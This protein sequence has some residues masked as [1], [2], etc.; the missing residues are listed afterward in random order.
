M[1]LRTIELFA[2]VYGGVDALVGQQ[3]VL[4]QHDRSVEVTRNDQVIAGPKN[5]SS[6]AYTASTLNAFVYP[7]VG[8]EAG[9]ELNVT[10]IVKSKVD[11][12]GAELKIGV[13]G[14]VESGAQISTTL[15]N[16]AGVYPILQ[17]GAGIIVKGE[18]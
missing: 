18:F 10:N 9:L 1:I 16:Q 7:H 5:I 2:G 6:A 17:G 13:L 12:H 14:T 15:S 3:Y 11:S 4:T 8:A